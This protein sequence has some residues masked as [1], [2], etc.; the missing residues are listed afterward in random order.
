MTEFFYFIE[1][2]F[3]EILFIPLDFLRFLELKNWFLSNSVNF[4]F[5][6]I[7]SS[8]LTYWTIQLIGFSKR[9]EED[10]DQT[11]HSFL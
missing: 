10:T 2:L 9:N 1:Y 8:A 6:I 11:A 4:F 5:M 7:I 3:V